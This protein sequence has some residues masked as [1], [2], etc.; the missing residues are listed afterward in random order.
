MPLAATEPM[1]L[2]ME[3]SV[4]LATDHVKVADWPGLN[5]ARFHAEIG[6]ARGG[7]R[8]RRRLAVLTLGGGGGGGAGTFFLHALT[9][10]I[11]T[12]GEHRCTQCSLIHSHFFDVPP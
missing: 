3:I 8:R 9:D 4:A 1:P 7:S 12:H 6:D 5:G 10:S 2:L 11:N